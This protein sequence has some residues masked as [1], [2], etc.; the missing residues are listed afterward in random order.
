VRV[1]FATRVALVVIVA[2][3]I[4]AAGSA[5]AAAPAA[6]D[7][8]PPTRSLVDWY[9]MGGGLMHG[10]S[11]CSVLILGTIVERAYALRG[12]ATVPRRLKGEIERALA[13]GNL[14]ELKRLCEGSGSALARLAGQAL[15][16]AVT[17]DTIESA[18]AYEAHRML[19]NL[20]LLVA[21]GNL[22]TMIGLLGTV[23]GMIDAFDRIALVGSGDA[24]VVAG[25]IFLALI[26]TAAGLF[27]A[28]AA[29]AAHAWLSR[30]AD[31]VVSELERLS[32]EI[33]QAFESVS[34]GGRRDLGSARDGMA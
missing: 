14:S 2:N 23:L 32:G 5:I 17:P 3:L 10:L 21:L 27:A 18:G 29:V 24:R 34:I 8:A 12:A 28:I 33:R 7:A 26:T 1:P 4:W 22:S 9:V 31:D 15:D 25:G 16:P 11:V 13:V 30:R 19:R 20:P 6:S